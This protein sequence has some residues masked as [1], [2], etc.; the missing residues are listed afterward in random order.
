MQSPNIY[1]RSQSGSSQQQFMDPLLGGHHHHNHH[2]QR[3]LGYESADEAELSRGGPLQMH[4]HHHHHHHHHRLQQQTHATKGLL[5][6]DRM[7][8]RLTNTTQP[9]PK[10]H[11]IK[12]EDGEEAYACCQVGSSTCDS[13]AAAAHGSCSAT[14]NEPN[15]GGGVVPSQSPTYFTQLVS[16]LN[17]RLNDSQSNQMVAND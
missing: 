1:L 13:A 8:A 11:L 12:Y 6:G 15:G 3:N 9:T 4:H 2:H 14:V 16:R 7:N 10:E 17:Q 5:T